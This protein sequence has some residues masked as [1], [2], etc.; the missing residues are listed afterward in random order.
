MAIIYISYANNIELFYMYLIRL[1]LATE[2][3]ILKKKKN[4]IYSNGKITRILWLWFFFLKKKMN[5]S[6][7]Q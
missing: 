5:R 2:S 7:N 1:K 3:Y 6:I 4:A